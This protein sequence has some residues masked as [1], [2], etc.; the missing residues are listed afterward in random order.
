[1]RFMQGASADRTYVSSETILH[2]FR[3]RT[4]YD[5]KAEI[6]EPPGRRQGG[7]GSA[8]LE[9]RLS[10]VINVSSAALS[11]AKLTREMGQIK[12]GRVPPTRRP[13]TTPSTARSVPLGRLL[14]AIPRSR[15]VAN[16][17]FNKLWT[18]GWLNIP[19]QGTAFA[20]L[21]GSAGRS[22]APFLS[23]FRQVVRQVPA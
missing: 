12:Y 6:N 3:Y 10:I 19:A 8:V 4:A 16:A 20:A 14:L 17:P 5:R 2:R 11:S 7:K 22:F 18:R 21:P 9:T 13:L 23:A 1:M 15:D